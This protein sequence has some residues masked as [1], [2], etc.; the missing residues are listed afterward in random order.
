VRRRFQSGGDV[1][2]GRSPGGRSDGVSSKGFVMEVVRATPP[3]ASRVEASVPRPAAWQ[4][5][6]V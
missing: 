4:Q 3:P 1:R 2:G 6:G 5:R